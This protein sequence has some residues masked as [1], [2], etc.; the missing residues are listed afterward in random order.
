MAADRAWFD[1]RSRTLAG[2]LELTAEAHTTQSKT[3]PWISDA[4][5]LVSNNL[6]G[7]SGAMGGHVRRNRRDDRFAVFALGL[8]DDR[9]F[10]VLPSSVRGL[11]ISIP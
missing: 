9:Y 1:R 7:M 4:C 11:I 6:G 10:Y 3:P 8:I 5:L 2:L